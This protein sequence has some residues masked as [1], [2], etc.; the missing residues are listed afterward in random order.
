MPKLLVEELEIASDFEMTTEASAPTG[1]TADSATKAGG[2]PAVVQ[3][4]LE[5]IRR[6]IRVKVVTSTHKGTNK[7]GAKLRTNS[8]SIGSPLTSA[9]ACAIAKATGKPIT[10][11]NEEISTDGKTLEAKFRIHE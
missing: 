5:R 7:E 11:E 9:I 2:E 6:P 1:S 10:I 8:F 4:K 3:I